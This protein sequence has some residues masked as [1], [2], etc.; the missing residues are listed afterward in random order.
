MSINEVEHYGQHTMPLEEK[1][2]KNNTPEACVIKEENRTG[3]KTAKQ[4][5]DSINDCEALSDE[6]KK[7][8][9]SQFVTPQVS[10]ALDKHLMRLHAT[11]DPSQRATLEAILITYKS[12]LHE[13]HKIRDLNI[14]LLNKLATVHKENNQS[15]II[16]KELADYKNKI[17]QDAHLKEL[18]KQKRLNKIKRPK[19]TP[20]LLEHFE[21]TIDQIDNCQNITENTK[22]RMRIITVIF[23]ITGAR[24]SEIK[25]IKVS[26]ILTL[27]FKGY[28]AIDRQKRGPSN[29]KA[30]LK[31]SAKK[32]LDTYRHDII[33]ILE[34]NKIRITDKPLPTYY[35]QPYD[36]LYFFSSEKNKGKK[37][38][39]RAHFTDAYN[40]LLQSLDLGQKEDLHFTSHSL[41]HGFIH[42]LW[43]ETEDIKFV[44]NVI[45]HVSM[46]TTS[47][48]ADHMT[49]SARKTRMENL[50]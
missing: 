38:F 26:Q 33:K 39:S 42:E 45:G 40:K 25:D 36:Q 17:E 37:P 15:L 20:F 21:R 12:Q 22:L 46:A 14:N 49:E 9:V 19:T 27:I 24:I 48:Y 47:V 31:K 32:I 3:L 8:L 35:I 23:I 44:Q 30:F 4:V 5:V 43:T 18:A 41:R 50:N 7:E 29:Y 1:L 10:E 34:H 16:I 28:I 6:E 2:A 11:A 13:T